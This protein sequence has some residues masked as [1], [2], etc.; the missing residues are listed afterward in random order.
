MSQCPYPETF[1]N[2]VS[3]QTESN[4]LY[5]VWHEG[6]EAHKFEIAN[7][8]IKIARLAVE[9]E[10][11]IRKITEMKRELEKIKKQILKDASF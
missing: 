1:I 11:E 4:S 6:Y 7:L 8:S 3:L 9:L 10:N 2:P 5:F